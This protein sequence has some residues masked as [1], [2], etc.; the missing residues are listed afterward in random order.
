[1]PSL[2]RIH[3]K[4]KCWLR[5]IIA[6]IWHHQGNKKAVAL[7]PSYQGRLKNTLGLV[8]VHAAGKE[9][10]RGLMTYVTTD[11]LTTDDI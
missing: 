9:E 10:S 1:L 8:A 11:A 5:H 7:L 6:H 3:C 4:I 2:P